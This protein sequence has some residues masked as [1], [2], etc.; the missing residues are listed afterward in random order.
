MC[1]THKRQMKLVWWM[2]SDMWPYRECGQRVTFDTAGRGVHYSKMLVFCSSEVIRELQ[3]WG[4]VRNVLYC[5]CAGVEVV[6]ICQILMF[7]GS[8]RGRK[9]NYPYTPV[10]SESYWGSACLP[11]ECMLTGGR[12][13]SYYPSS[14]AGACG[15]QS[16]MSATC[17][18]YYS[19]PTTY[20][21]LPLIHLF[22]TNSP[23]SPP[24]I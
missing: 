4:W 15:N 16:A 19:T 8:Y 6:G 23:T 5:K 9:G 20:I 13:S 1:A 7:L 17:Y 21:H 11:G 24:Y 14:P 2:R 18:Q 10:R 22:H 12:Q 3:C